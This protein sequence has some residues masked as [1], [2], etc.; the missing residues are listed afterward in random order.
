MSLKT[1]SNGT[2]AGVVRKITEDNF[3]TVAKHLHQNMLTLS[4]EER[5]L[6]GKEYLSD[7]LVVYDKNLMTFFEYVQSTGL[8]KISPLSENKSFSITFSEQDWVNNTIYISFADH[9]IANPN[10]QM[11]M[12][13]EETYQ[14][15]LGGVEIDTEFN[16]TLHT[17]M[18][19]AGRVVVK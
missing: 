3:K 17:D 4:T 15:V 13:M 18:P 19:F 6:L 9:T 2:G 1:W 5:L 10:V 14:P 11:F 12:L 7:G 8:W 16:V